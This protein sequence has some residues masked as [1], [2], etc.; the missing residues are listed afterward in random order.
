MPRRGMS[1]DDDFRIKDVEEQTKKKKKDRKDEAQEEGDRGDE[2]GGPGDRG[3]RERG[4]PE[5]EMM[6]GDDFRKPRP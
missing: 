6:E 4:F 1:S 3:R 5:T 2:R